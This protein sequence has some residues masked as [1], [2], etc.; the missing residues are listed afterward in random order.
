MPALFIVLFCNISNNRFPYDLAPTS[1]GM[2]LLFSILKFMIKKEIYPFGMY[3][4]S[5]EANI[6]GGWNS[7]FKFK[8]L[9]LGHSVIFVFSGNSTLWFAGWFKGFKL[10]QQFPAI[11][12]HFFILFNNS[13]GKYRCIILYSIYRVIREIV[14]RSIRKVHLPEPISSMTEKFPCRLYFAGCPFICMVWLFE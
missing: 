13:N 7:R 10:A 5:L 2:E 8:V 4:S 11:R 1:T 14:Y 3:D 9:S 12:T 6:S